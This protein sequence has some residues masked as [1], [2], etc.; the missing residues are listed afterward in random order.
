[1]VRVQ[2]SRTIVLILFGISTLPTPDYK[3]LISGNVVS[4]FVIPNYKKG[5]RTVSSIV[6][7]QVK[8]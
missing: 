7:L 8:L 6:N 1:M 4:L 2:T 5:A 3:K